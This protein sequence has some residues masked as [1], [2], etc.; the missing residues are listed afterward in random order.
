MSV[1][2]RHPVKVPVC[3]YAPDDADGRASALGFGD[4]ILCQHVPTWEADDRFHHAD[5]DVALILSDDGRCTPLGVASVS[6]ALRRPGSALPTRS[7]QV[8]LR[9]G[10]E[11]RLGELVASL[12]DT[13][14]TELW[15]RP[16]NQQM[17]HLIQRRWPAAYNCRRLHLMLT[18]LPVDTEPLATRALDP[19]NPEDVAAV[20][21]VN[22][23]AF[24]EHPDQAG[25]T[26]ESV[27]KK[28][29]E[30]GH[31]AEGVRLAIIDGV[32][33][34]FCWTQIHHD[35]SLGEISVIGLHPDVHGRGLGGP[36]TAAGLRWLHDQG[37]RQAILYVEA[38]NEPAVR[39]Y[40]RLGFVT[41]HDD[42][43]WMIPGGAPGAEAGP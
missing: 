22:N 32:V 25:M 24:A 35:R 43:S 18:E 2:P 11:S 8:Y 12:V 4:R 34:G 27:Q 7:T 15:I 41:V 20:V 9:P 28:L 42:V 6:T 5:G 21:R 38:H 37:L 36:M 3:V 31:S 17:I 23:S 19:S 26:A 16:E 30:L 29:R 33:N 1:Q 10:H 14:G 40:H 39:S 13:E